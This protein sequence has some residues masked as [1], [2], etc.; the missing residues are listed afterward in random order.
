MDSE[1]NKQ[2]EEM[3]V[4]EHHLQTLLNQ[5]Q[6]VQI[7]L[8]EIENAL[9]ELKN[10]DDEVYKFLSGIMIRSDKKTLNKE[11][12]ERKKIA[13]MK[14]YSIE[15]QEKLIEGKSAELKKEINE[16]VSKNKK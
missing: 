2:I 4:L 8:N 3:Q 10:S 16:S 11:L 6:V 7:E 12:G 9:S 13:E 15:K 14:I 1:T 5:K